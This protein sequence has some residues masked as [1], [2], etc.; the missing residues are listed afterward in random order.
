[1]KLEMFQVTTS[2]FCCGLVVRGDVVTDDVAP[3]MSWTVGKCR[4]EI[5]KW[6]AK[7]GGTIKFVSSWEE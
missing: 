4:A 5:R 6:I 2:Y 7:K 1:V 3:I